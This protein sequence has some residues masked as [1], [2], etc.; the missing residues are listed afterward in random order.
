MFDDWMTTAEAAEF[1]GY[2]PEHLRRLIRSGGIEGRKF[3]IVWQVSRQSLIAY[4]EAANES[5]DK[6]RG[7]KN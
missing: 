6:R 2:H 4:L 7:A 1:S 5:D 3:G